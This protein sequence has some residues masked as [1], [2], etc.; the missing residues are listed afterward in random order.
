M[1]MRIPFRNVFQKVVGVKPRDYG[2]RF[3]VTPPTPF[4]TITDC[5]SDTISMSPMPPYSHSIVPG[6][7]LV[8]S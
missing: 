4:V 5:F 7:L 3:A 6:G 1:R 8:T 2:Q